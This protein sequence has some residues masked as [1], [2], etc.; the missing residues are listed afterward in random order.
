MG[1]QGGAA[2][3]LFMVGCAFRFGLGGLPSGGKK[4]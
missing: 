2:V 1:E 4:E 3:L